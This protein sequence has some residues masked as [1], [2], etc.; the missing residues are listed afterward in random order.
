MITTNKHIGGESCDQDESLTIP[1]N[2]AIT[3]VDFDAKEP[4]IKVI[5]KDE[6]LPE[7]MIKIL[8]PKALAHY[9][10]THSCGSNKMIEHFK[11]QGAYEVRKQIKEAIGFDNKY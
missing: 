6:Y 4:Y 1:K 9:L 8:I 5:P 7:H 3:H 10:T 11:Q 2:H